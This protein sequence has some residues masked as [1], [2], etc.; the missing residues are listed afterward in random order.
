[1]SDAAAIVCV[2]AAAA[3]AAHVC[4]FG[5]Q[6]GW[7]PQRAQQGW[8]L[9]QQ[10][11]VRLCIHVLLFDELAMAPVPMAARKA[12]SGMLRGGRRQHCMLGSV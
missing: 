8:T 3:A 2:A 6:A 1:V 7:R 11:Q 5:L 4:L 10:G 9:A 12:H